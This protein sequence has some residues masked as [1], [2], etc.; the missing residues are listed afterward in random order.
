LVQQQKWG[1]KFIKDGINEPERDRLL[2][3]VAR[4]PPMKLRLGA[5]IPVKFPSQHRPAKM[6]L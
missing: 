2:T 5:I 1:N 6:L 4:A 3:L